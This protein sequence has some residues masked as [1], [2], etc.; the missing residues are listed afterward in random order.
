MADTLIS[1][2]NA[3]NHATTVFPYNET[4]TVGS[5]ITELLNGGFL[6]AS[7]GGHRVKLLPTGQV[8]SPSERI[9]GLPIDIGSRLEFSA[10]DRPSIDKPINDG[11]RIIPGT[12]FPDGGDDRFQK[13]PCVLVLDHSFSMLAANKIDHLNAALQT[14]AEYL[15]KD[16]NTRR[17]VKLLLITCGGRVEKASDWIDAAEFRPPVLIP[18][19]DTPLGQAV[20]LALDEVEQLKA[21]FKRENRPYTRPVVILM[22]DGVPTDSGWEAAAD[23]SQAAMLGKHAQVWPVPII[24]ADGT[25]ADLNVLRRFKAPDGPMMQINSVANFAQFFEFL[26]EV[27]K[28]SSA[29]KPNNALEVPIDKNDPQSAKITVLT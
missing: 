1:I 5:L 4:D 13:T 8:L 11:S 3:N 15:S 18:S 17:R 12:V 6:T 27:L 20:N 9:A 19:G 26:R 22:T 28:A 2:V 29:S 14:F 10:I 24:A 7:S 25:G 23:R 16:E 21:Q